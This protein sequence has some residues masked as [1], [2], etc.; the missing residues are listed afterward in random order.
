M[1]ALPV[2][3]SMAGC[4]GC[5]IRSFITAISH[6]IG[7]IKTF[8]K[9]LMRNIPCDTMAMGKIGRYIGSTLLGLAIA[10]SAEVKASMIPLEWRL[11]PDYS[12]IAELKQY[13]SV[14]GNETYYDIPGGDVMD[15][16]GQALDTKQFRLYFKDSGGQI[17]GIIPTDSGA[18]GTYNFGGTGQAIYGDLDWT[19]DT[20][21]GIQ[22]WETP[23]IIAL[24]I[25]DSF[26]DFYIG[27]IISGKLKTQGFSSLGNAIG[28]NNIEIDMSRPLVPE[29]SM[30]AILGIG[31]G[32][33]ALGRRKE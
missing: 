7:V 33:L 23:G 20:D 1:A 18:P 25:T 3:I 6:S 2:L 16:N 17:V 11:A 31:T 21:E 5:F 30:L 14:Q 8:L 9:L 27:K 13:D 4:G 22:L 10:G 19:S 12:N 29:P 26:S 28:V 32:A 15:E 24:D